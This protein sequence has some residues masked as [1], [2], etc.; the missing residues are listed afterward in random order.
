MLQGILFALHTGIAW[1]HLP[2]EL[3]Y[4]SGMTCWRRLAE[5]Q[6]AGSGSACTRSYSIACAPPMQ[7]T[8]P[9]LSW[10]PPTSER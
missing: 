1:E 3:G 8:S 6:K 10:T 5:W 7:S 9:A 2:Q 4:G